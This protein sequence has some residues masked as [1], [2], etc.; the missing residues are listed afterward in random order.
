MPHLIFPV[1]QVVFKDGKAHVQAG[2]GIV[3]DSVP[4]NEYQ[5]SVNKSM[6]IITA[7][8]EAGNIE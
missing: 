8:R 4:E 2:G 1:K 7:I 5:E 6:S 3:Y